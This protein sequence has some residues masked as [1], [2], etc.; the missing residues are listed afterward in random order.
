MRVQRALE[1]ASSERRSRP[2]SCPGA[3]RQETLRQRVSRTFCSKAH[4]VSC[5]FCQLRRLR[6]LGLWLKR[7]LDPTIEILQFSMLESLVDTV[8]QIQS[9]SLMFTVSKVLVVADSSIPCQLCVRENSSQTCTTTASK[10]LT[11]CMNMFVPRFACFHTGHSVTVHLQSS[12]STPKD[13]PKGSL[14]ASLRHQLTL[15]KIE[16]QLDQARSFVQDQT[17]GNKDLKHVAKNVTSTVSSMKRIQ[18]ILPRKT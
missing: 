6:L 10:Q 14:V 2:A 12:R 13:F 1:C 4:H 5:R 16:H 17:Q 7:C 15:G 3:V 11:K 8:V 9:M 18:S